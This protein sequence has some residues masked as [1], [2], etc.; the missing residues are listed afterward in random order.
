MSVGATFISY[1]F[2]SISGFSKIGTYS[3]N[4]STQAITGLGFSP[5]WVL[6]K[7]IEGVDSWELYDTARGA[8]SV[9]YPNGN[10]AEG[11]NSGLTSFD[12]DG[13][14]LGSATSAN[15]SGKNLPLHG[16]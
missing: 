1:C 14:T 5:S 3:G 11:N 4:S 6:L 2:A 8:T 7:E 12:S 16:L 10:N 15:E 9:L 13:F